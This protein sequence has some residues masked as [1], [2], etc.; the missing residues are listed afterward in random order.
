MRNPHPQLSHDGVNAGRPSVVTRLHALLPSSPIELVKKPT[1]PRTDAQASSPKSLSG[2]APRQFIKVRIMSWNMHDSVPKGDLTELLGS[3]PSHISIPVSPDKDVGPPMLP[4]DDEHPYHIVVIAGQECPSASGIPMALGAGFKLK[5]KDKGRP[6]SV[7]GRK[8]DELNRKDS[9]YHGS[10]AKS[11][12]HLSGSPQGYQLLRSHSQEA[13]AG[14]PEIE[15]GHQAHKHERLLHHHSIRDHTPGWSSMLEQWYSNPPTTHRSTT[16]LPHIPYTTHSEPELPSMP[17]DT[18]SVEAESPTAKVAPYELLLK[19]RMMGL[20]LAIFININCRDLVQGTSRS[21]VTAGLIGG[22][23]GNKGGIGISIK[24]YDTS[25]LFINAHLAAHEGRVQHRLADLAKIKSEL[26]VDDFLPSSDPRKMAEDLTDRFDHTFIFGDLNFRLDVSRLHADWL[27]SRKEYGQALAFDQLRKVMESGE[28]FVEFNEAPIT[29]PPTFK[30]DVLRTIKGS[31][32]RK[33]ARESLP[34][35]AKHDKVLSGIQESGP[36]YGQ[37]ETRGPQAEGGDADAESVASSTWTSV[38]SR[39][40]INADSTEEQHTKHLLSTAVAKVRTGNIAQRL[41]VAVTSNKVKTKWVQRL[42]GPDK[43]RPA[44]RLSKRRRAPH[45]NSRPLSNLEVSV[46]AV[47]EA[48]E[49][50]IIAAPKNQTDMHS[51]DGATSF[52]RSRTDLNESEMNPEDRGIYD[53]SHKQRVPSWCD[54]ILWRSTVDPELDELV[55]PEPY[56]TRVSSLLHALRPLRTRKDSAYSG[57]QPGSPRTPTL[58]VNT[59]L[60]TQDSVEIPTSAVIQLSRPRSMDCLP[61]PAS[62]LPSGSGMQA[63]RAWRRASLEQPELISSRLAQAQMKPASVPL[64]HSQTMPPV[65]SSP[66]PSSGHPNRTPEL[67]DMQST[68]PPASRWFGFLPFINRDPTSHSRGPTASPTPDLA[69]SSPPPRRGDVVCLS[70]RS[71]DDYGMRRLEGRS[72]HRP[73][74][75]SYAIYV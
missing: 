65:L 53:S 8:Q 22:R 57:I 28:A 24:I 39:Y 3:L 37:A 58:M 43:Q 74:I 10:P 32:S 14:T 7:H 63:K 34:S 16:S 6:E 67:S 52:S 17:A 1:L 56:R 61:G 70:Y 19:E 26:C 9:K 46:A 38:R 48:L 4:L 2:P 49:T 12:G 41:W 5:D 11:V 30:Y 27:I 73:V 66:R 54:R 40:T 64:L 71:L 31:K 62:P 51:F 72:D 35:P 21:A 20:Y 15:Q 60:N 69:R 45:G 47:S 13:L 23:V 36:E 75:G 18:K 50:D 42:S 68:P 44:R 33:S 55:K 25:F 59:H 29:F